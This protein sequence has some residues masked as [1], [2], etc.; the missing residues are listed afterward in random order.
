MLFATFLRGFFG[1]LFIPTFWLFYSDNPLLLEFWMD[2]FIYKGSSIY[3]PIAFFASLYFYIIVFSLSFW[4]TKNKIFSPYT[5]QVNRIFDDEKSMTAITYIIVLFFFLRKALT[6]YNDTDYF[7]HPFFDNLVFP[8]IFPAQ[9]THIFLPNTLGFAA[10]FILLT[11]KK[12]RKSKIFGAILFLLFSI[13]AYNYGSRALIMQSIFL[14]SCSMYLIGKLTSLRII[15][16]AMSGLLFILFM[17]YSGET[18]LDR[19]LSFIM[20]LDVYHIVAHSLQ[21]SEI[22]SG[23]FNEYAREVGLISNLDYNTGVGF[24]IFYDLYLQGIPLSLSII[25]G[26][27]IFGI[28]IGTLLLLVNSNNPVITSIILCYVFKVVVF[29]PDMAIYPTFKMVTEFILLSAG[30]YILSALFHYRRLLARD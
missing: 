30:I 16:I 28:L 3:V 29:W 11:Y 4:I 14:F 20:R 18:L 1:F 25:I 2:Y 27:T 13:A 26:G 21:S 19:I 5:A 8:E 23:N 12:S 9:I 24:P 15:I 10:A 7:N 17:A 22:K 6:F